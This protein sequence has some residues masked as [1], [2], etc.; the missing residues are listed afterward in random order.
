M[1]TRWHVPLLITVMLIAWGL[2]T[3]RLNAPWVGHQDE[4]G[5]WISS[6]IRN[7]QQIGFGALNGM[8]LHES[9]LFTLLLNAFVFRS[10]DQSFR[11]GSEPFTWSAY[12]ARIAVRW[13]TLLTPGTFFLAIL[14]LIWLIRRQERTRVWMFAWLIGGLIF[15]L[16]FRNGAYL[17]DYY[18]I[19][20]VP[21]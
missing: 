7:Y 10:S 14:G 16:V 2:L 15:I 1:K 20:T 18:L 19:Y 4:N 17:H 11:A 13:I 6:A 12:A 8:I 21:H 9:D 5:A 3:F